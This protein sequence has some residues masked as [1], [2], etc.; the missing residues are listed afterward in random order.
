VLLLL[1][2]LLG[3]GTVAMDVGAR[4][5]AAGRSTGANDGATVVVDSPFNV[6]LLLVGAVGVPP[7]FGVAVGDGV[8]ATGEVGGAVVPVVVVGVGLVTFKP[9]EKVQVSGQSLRTKQ[10][11]GIT[12]VTNSSPNINS[13]GSSGT[14]AASHVTHA[15]K[16]SI[17][18]TQ[19][20]MK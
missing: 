4:I 7:A 19:G 14:T 8:V 13:G 6:V 1:L 10:S 9:G 20:L 5:G 16:F 18:G 2:L 3:V 12:R 15:V 17:F 11:Q